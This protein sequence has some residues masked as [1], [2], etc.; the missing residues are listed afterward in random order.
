MRDVL[1]RIAAWAVE[2]PA[3]VVALA[4]LLSLVGAVGALGLEADRNPDSLVDS[5]SEA[6]EA[7]EDFYDE[8]GGEPVRILVEGDLQQLMLSEDL[9][10]ILALEACLA[11]S[12][13]EGRVFGE[14]ADAPDV[15]ARLS[16][17]RPADVVFGPATFLN[18]TAI[19]AENVLRDQTEAAE[20]QAA[21]AARE[22]ANAAKE[23]G[24]S[25]DD[26]LRNAEA[27]YQEVLAGFQEQLLQAATRYGLSGIPRIDDP[28]Y[29][30]AVVFDPAQASG[31][32]KARF[33]FLFPNAGAAMITV[34]LDPGLSQGER[35]R[36][37]GLFR[38]AVADPAFNL[39]SGEYV[40]S[41]VPVIFD[42]LAQKLSTEIFVLLA[43]ALA[44][45]A[46][47][48]ALV[49]GPPLRLL[50]LAI[51]LGSTGVVFG[52][53]AVFGGS[54]TM[55]SI[56]VLPVLTGLAVDYA[57]QFQAR[58]RE[59][60]DGG[61]S[62]PRA[63]VEAAAK[64]GPV[65][66]TALLATAAGFLVLLLSPI[67]MIRGFGL[68]L[69]VGVGV[70]FVFALT[71]G[72]A[73]LSMVSKPRTPKVRRRSR[74]ADSRESARRRTEAVGK[75]LSSWGRSALAASIGAPGKV[76]LA[77][78]ILAVA[79][80]IAGTRTELVSDIRQ[81]LPADLPELEDVDRLEET[82]GVSGD[83]YVTVEAEDL[84]D[85][86]VIAW[87]AEYE[88]R[89]L[90]RHG[91]EPGESTCQDDDVE[92]CPGTTLATL[93]AGQNLPSRTQIR[94]LLDLLPQYFSQA[95][96]S[97]DE[98][99]DGGT[100]LIG[101]GIRVQPFDEQK[102]LIDDMRSQL[103]TP[104]TEFDPPEGVEVEVVGLPVLAADANAALGSNRYL[105]TGAGLLVIALVLLAVY[106]SLARALVPLIPI[107]L[108]TG[109]SS[110][111]VEAAGVPLN[112]MSAT[113][114]ALVVAITTEFSVILAA[115]FHEE[116]DRGTSVGQALRRTYA[117]TG[118]AVAASG[119]TAIAGFAVLIA[120]DVRMLRDFGL[121]TVFDLAVA[122][123][124]VML[125]L[126]AALVWAEG[127]MLELRERLRRRPRPAT[128]GA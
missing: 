99:G 105:L 74:G 72:L 115:R 69:V 123:A 33:N 113:L 30:S 97:R 116:R 71:A 64:G 126:P 112:P 24:A 11:G 6:F 73:A 65:I 85:P 119:A 77:G 70:A 23:A 17:E 98:S 25:E 108:A 59:S 107:V 100:A 89:L 111:V 42:G 19:T 60:L 32:P 61:S 16:E 21:V 5:G 102:E 80:W 76:L 62:P 94:E 43:V 54:L 104:G 41:G 127:G 13:P 22:A 118:A 91:Y 3:P 103:D 78:L 49:F 9:G 56:A 117:R 52:L 57:I 39:R 68:L 14:D 53:L 120:S 90:T 82:T 110:L 121:V 37:I 40:V 109:W 50:P 2:R 12:S 93:F 10:T 75:T 84:T 27:A 47:V 122:L 28:T 4:I 18:Q 66:A 58:F 46:I 101:F 86:Q 114:G 83:V 45:M 128:E 67:P 29:V 7:T 36:A 34:R 95:V 1:T 35:E 51:A 38:E 20:Q 81:L 79:G 8:F 63:A 87:M 26:Q 44:V 48:L 92:L 55:A 31:T 106:R 96:V 15:C 124:G 125:V 88:Q